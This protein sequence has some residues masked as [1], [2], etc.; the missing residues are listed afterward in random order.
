MFEE[1]QIPKCDKNIQTIFSASDREKLVQEDGVVVIQYTRD[2]P[3]SDAG[4]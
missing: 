3:V 2:I 1:T 4:L